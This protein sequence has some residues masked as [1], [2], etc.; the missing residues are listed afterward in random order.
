MP[1]V[2][3]LVEGVRA[4]NRAAVS[5]AI[6]LVESTSARHRERPGSC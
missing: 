1:E 4:Q 5:Q 6:T 3:E 2:G